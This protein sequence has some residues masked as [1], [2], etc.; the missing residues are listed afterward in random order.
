MVNEHLLPTDDSTVL[1]VTVLFCVY[2]VAV[3]AVI[4]FEF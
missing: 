2:T 4:H 1:R 3:G